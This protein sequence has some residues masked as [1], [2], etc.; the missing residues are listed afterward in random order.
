[1]A[2]E[3]NRLLR[4]ADRGCFIASGAILAGIAVWS[5]AGRVADVTLPARLTSSS[6]FDVLNSLPVDSLL[7]FAP[8]GRTS[9]TSQDMRFL[10][11][12]TSTLSPAFR[13]CS[14]TIF[15]SPWFDCFR[16]RSR[17]PW[18]RGFN[19]PRVPG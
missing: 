7:T 11:T 15:V 17:P 18:A 1:M 2:S 6:T 5:V 16:F 4:I 10:P 3:Q 14:L 12:L 8:S 9:T 19:R 13:L